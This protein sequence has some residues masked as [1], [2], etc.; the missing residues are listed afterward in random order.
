MPSYGWKVFLS[1]KSNYEGAKQEEI[2]LQLKKYNSFEIK[3][4]YPVKRLVI[5]GTSLS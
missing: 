5:T 4:L 3:N 1:I 2:T